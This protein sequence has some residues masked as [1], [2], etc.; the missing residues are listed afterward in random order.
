M[1]QKCFDIILYNQHIK[2]LYDEESG[3]IVRKYGLH[4]IEF[5]I[6]FFI[7]ST[8]L[9]RAKDI[10]ENTRF[11]K[12]YISNAI[13]NL[14][15][16]GYLICVKDNNDKRCIRLQL[17]DK[18][19]AIIND[20][21]DFYQHMLNIITKDVTQEEMDTMNCIFE[22]IVKNIN[23]ELSAVKHYNN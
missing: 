14:T 23:T 20:I 6:L 3:I 11:S 8:R 10:A 21:A 12:A 18:S 16:S 5:E 15:S 4:K 22:K 9:N 1:F 19:Y 2:K 13:E 7:Y 17:T